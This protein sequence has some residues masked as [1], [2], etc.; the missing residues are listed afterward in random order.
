MYCT[1]VCP[2]VCLYARL[3]VVLLCSILV[4]DKCIHIIMVCKKPSLPAE[5]GALTTNTTTMVQHFSETTTGNILL[6]GRHEQH[7]KSKNRTEAAASAFHSVSM[8]WV[9]GWLGGRVV[10]VPDSGSEK[11]W[12]KSQSRRC[13]VADLGKLFTPIV[14]R[15]T[16]PCIPSGSLNRVPA[17]NTVWSHMVSDFP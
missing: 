12:F 4:I 9:I 17:G 7:N 13:R 11:H 3:S 5:S 8:R 2:S 15:E 1:S 14:P 10:S 16:Q 6:H